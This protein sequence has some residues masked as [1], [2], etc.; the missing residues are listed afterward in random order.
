MVGPYKAGGRVSETA[1]VRT[2]LGRE[3]RIHEVTSST[4]RMEMRV[5]K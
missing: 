1:A 2:D 5:R 3:W 4:S